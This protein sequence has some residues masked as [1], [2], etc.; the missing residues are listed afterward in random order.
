MTLVLKHAGVPH[1]Y[2]DTGV[3]WNEGRSHSMEALA[4]CDATSDPTAPLLP[5]LPSAV[6]SVTLP[7]PYLR[8]SGSHGDRTASPGTGQCVEWSAMSREQTS[9]RWDGTGPQTLAGRS[10]ATTQRPSQ[11]AVCTHRRWRHHGNSNTVS[12]HLCHSFTWTRSIIVPR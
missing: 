9:C 12:S 11:P 6:T 10:N 8:S 7:G 4:S 1:A 5:S 3:V 2:L